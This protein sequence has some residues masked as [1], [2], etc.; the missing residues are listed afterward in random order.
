VVDA[1]ANNVSLSGALLSSPVAFEPGEEVV[2]VFN[3]PIARRPFSIP[4]RVIRTVLA[5][6]TTGGW[7]Y[8]LGVQYFHLSSELLKIFNNFFVICSRGTS[9]EIDAQVSFNNR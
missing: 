1:Q 5:T 9:R 6:S 3:V 2:V 4:A 8:E 7:R